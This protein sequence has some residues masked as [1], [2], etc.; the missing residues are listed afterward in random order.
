[1]ARSATHAAVKLSAPDAVREKLRRAI[2]SGKLAPGLQLKQDEL[3]ERFGMSR[4][5]VREA[6]RQLEVEGYV[7]IHPNRGAVVAELSLDEVVELME[8]RTALECHAL[9]L[10]IP[11][12][13]DLDLETAEG[14]LRAYDEAPE[15]ETWGEMNWAF[16]VTLYAPCDRPKLLAMIEANYGHVSRF[17][18]GLVS[19]TVGK[20]RPQHE[21]YQLLGACRKGD[22][23][24]ALYLLGEHI[25]NTRKS[26][27]ALARRRS[28]GRS[29][30]G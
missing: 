10:A 13:S 4:I 18:R 16:H 23:D 20:E 11:Q 30:A 28:V 12:M 15:P 27:M 2:R 24:R 9:R 3:A 8:I 29:S 5:P 21:H 6:L 1:M 26:L 17:I 14:I 19:R 7:T 22:V 25:E